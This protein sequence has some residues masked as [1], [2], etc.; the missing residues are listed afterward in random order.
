MDNRMELAVSSDKGQQFVKTPQELLKL[1]GVFEAE[2]LAYVPQKEFH[3][4]EK[5]ILYVVSKQ[6]AKNCEKLA[7]AQP[8]LTELWSYGFDSCHRKRYFSILIKL[9]R[10]SAMTLET[11][12]MAN[13]IFPLAGPKVPVLMN[14]KTL[15]ICSI[16]RTMDVVRIMQQIDF[17]RVLPVVAE[18]EIREGWISQSAEEFRDAQDSYEHPIVFNASATVKKLSL[19]VNSLCIEDV[20]GLSSVFPNVQNLVAQQVDNRD[21]IEYQDL[22]AYWPR[23]ISVSLT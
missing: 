11:I 3:M 2:E 4:L 23:L 19:E 18:V 21:H 10:S 8:K 15:I 20:R 7:E 6:T 17:C 12:R 14:V 9:L 5:L 22:Q 13:N 16:L 1:T